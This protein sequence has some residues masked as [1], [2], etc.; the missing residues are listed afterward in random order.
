[1]PKKDLNVIYWDSSA[2]LSTIFKDRH[3]AEAKRWVHKESIHLISTLA[4]TETCAVIARIQRDRLL[5]DVLIHAALEVLEKGPWQ[6]LNSLPEWKII[7][8]LS[9]KWSLRGADLW[10]LAAA[11]SLQKQLPELFLL[12]F[13]NRLKIAAKGEGMIKNSS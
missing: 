10:H 5:A 2:I 8:P 3:S 4:Y 12:T 6:H 13:D 11:K 9:V 7:Q 1:M